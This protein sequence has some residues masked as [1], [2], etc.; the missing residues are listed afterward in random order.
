MVLILVRV[1]CLCSTPEGQEW[2]HGDLPLVQSTEMTGKKFC[3]VG[4]LTS[5]KA[6]Q[7]IWLRARVHTSR[8]ELCLLRAAATAAAVGSKVVFFACSRVVFFA[9]NR[10]V[11]KRFRGITR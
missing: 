3:A 6:G 7:D 10:L 5:E 2:R 4:E 9:R 1:R 8:S 11:V